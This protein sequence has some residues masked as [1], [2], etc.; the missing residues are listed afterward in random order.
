[1]YLPAEGKR[2]RGTEYLVGTVQ[3]VVRY[4]APLEAKAA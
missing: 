1:M 2:D 4:V 3:A